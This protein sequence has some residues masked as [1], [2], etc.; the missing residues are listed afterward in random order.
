MHAVWN[1]PVSV[2]QV[3]AAVDQFYLIAINTSLSITRYSHLMAMQYIKQNISDYITF[4]KI[5]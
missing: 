5:H 4:S 2:L 3:G 1:T